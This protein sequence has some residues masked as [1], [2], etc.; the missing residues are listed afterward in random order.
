MRAALPLVLALLA[1]A[2]SVDV[3]G[4]ACTEPGT[5][6]ECP[7]GQACGL[8]RHCSARAASCTVCVS[9][10]TI[11]SGGNIV[12]CSPDDDAVCGSTKLVAGGDCVAKNVACT[13]GADGADA[14]CTCPAHEGSEYVVNPVAGRAAEGVP[15]PTGVS[16]PP[17]C[18]F[19][20]LRQGLAA[21][22]AT[23]VTM[24]GQPIP[25]TLVRFGAES[26]ETFPLDVPAGVTLSS[27]PDSDPRD[28]VIDAEESSASAI[29]V[30]HEGATIRGIT[31]RKIA[32][33]ARPATAGVGAAIELS[34]A[35]ATPVLL[36]NI[37]I[38][39]DALSYGVKAA[40]KCDAVLTSPV[41]AGPRAAALY[42]DGETASVTTTVIGGAFAAGISGDVDVHGVLLRG[43]K[44]ELKSAA[45]TTFDPRTGV[46]G[47]SPP[48]VVSGNSGNGVRVERN[49]KDTQ[50][51]LGLDRIVVSANAGAG[52]Y[53]NVSSGSLASIT[54]VDLRSNG[55]SP[56]YTDTGTN[57]ETIRSAGGLVITG[58]FTPATLTFKGNLV[59]NNTGEQIGIYRAGTIDL[60]GD[61]C[62]ATANVYTCVPPESA[63]AIWASPD[64]SQISVLKSFWNPDPPIVS[65]N[66]VYGT[67]CRLPLGQPLPSC[68]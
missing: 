3:E 60:S 57:P 45:D 64:V 2:C 42:V 29:L 56:Y 33:T 30:V 14:M 68:P 40:S 39:T 53:L 17:G 19:K 25:G 9:E 27:P 61:A 35:S 66:V 67:T 24:A 1:A 62:D 8:D 46:F 26:G 22:G 54:H 32:G 11:C 23:K 49:G 28:W 51:N 13:D 48:L 65:G 34:C 38:D 12:R 52:I 47:G 44:L 5:R 43:G 63:F 37:R 36:E 58:S 50:T 31:L 4:A 10:Q 18:S 16:S 21:T 15:A 55:A 41:I 6:T 7:S 20:T 59:R